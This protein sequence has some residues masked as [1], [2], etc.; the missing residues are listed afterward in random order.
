MKKTKKTS[1]FQNTLKEISRYPSAIFGIVV[2]L[3]LIIAAIVVVITIPYDEAITTWR[4]GEEIVEK[5]P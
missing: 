3:A 2:I 1:R 5:P 4:G